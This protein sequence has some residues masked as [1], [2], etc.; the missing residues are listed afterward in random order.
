MAVLTA[1][2]TQPPPAM[3]AMNPE[4][5]IGPELEAVIMRALEKN[6]AA[7]YASMNEFAAA[8]IATPEGAP[9]ARPTMGSIGDSRVSA[10]PPAGAVPTAAQFGQSS[11]STAVLPPNPVPQIGG[12]SA[13]GTPSAATSGKTT[14]LAGQT[15]TVAP[16]GSPSGGLIV[17]SLAFVVVALGVGGYVMLGRKS[18]P[19]T[20]PPTIAAEAHTA[21]APPAPPAPVAAPVPSAAVP[22]AVVVPVTAPPTEVRLHVE[23]DPPGATIT[24]GGF[25]VCAATPCDIDVPRNEG[26]ELDAQKGAA[27]GQVKIL[28]QESQT[29][30]MKLAVPAVKAKPSGPKMCEVEVEG[31][32]ILRPCAQ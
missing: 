16:A 9:F 14:P 26:V 4:L 23:S 10:F 5:A 11:P 20:P 7:R 22:A 1:T 29:V 24:K 27:R 17:G 32:K 13:L 15:S 8:L 12:T 30:T 25:Q 31:L 18:A 3:R 19:D 6:P 2:M 21:A 28:A